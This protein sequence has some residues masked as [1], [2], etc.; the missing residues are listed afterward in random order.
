MIDAK[1][2]RRVMRRV[3]GRRIGGPEMEA[4]MRAHMEE[5]AAALIAEGVAPG[6]ARRRARLAFGAADRFQEEAWDARPTRWLEHLMRDVRFAVRMLLRS[7]GYTVV[8]V[9]TL[10]LGIG[11]TT[12]LFT[13]VNGVLLRPLPYDDPDGL[14]LI[15]ETAEEGGWKLPLSAGNYMDVKE[16]ASAFTGMAA[17]RARTFSLEE[18]DGAV[19]VEGARV[20]AGLFEVMG[21]RPLLGRTFDGDDDVGG[22]APVVMLS[23]A[24]WQQ[25]FGGSLDVIGRTITLSGDRYTIIGVMPEEFTFP[26]GAEL[27]APFGFPARTALWTPMAWTAAEAQ[28]RGTQNLVVVARLRPDV[29]LEAARADLGTVARSMGDVSSQF[30]RGASLTAGSLQADAVAPVRARLLL[31]LAMATFVMLI[32]CVNVANLVLTR[33]L[34][35]ERELSL[36][37]ALGAGTA[38]V[39]LQVVTETLILAAF[40]AAAAIVASIAGT[41]AML[42]LVP[43][44]LPRADDV[45]VDATVLV[46]TIGVATVIGVTFGLAS[47]VQVDRSRLAESLAASGGRSTGRRH[48][49]VRS[50]LIAVEVAFA[51]ILLVGA[52]LLVTSFMRLQRV[53]TGFDHEHV[54]AADLLVPSGPG[55]DPARDGPRWVSTFTEVIDRLEQEP[56]IEIA[57]GTSLL[58]LSGRVETRS[59]A[60]DGRPRAPDA[61]PL[62]AE[63]AATAPGYLEALRIPIVRGRTL[64]EQDREDAPLVVVVNEAFAARHFPGENPIGQRLSFTFTN[65]DSREIVGVAANVRSRG[66][67]AEVEP[68]IYLPLRQMPYPFLSITVRTRPGVIA[69]PV[70]FR[71]A[72]RTVDAGLAWGD[73]RPLGDVVAAS[74]AQRRFSA[75]LVGSFAAVALVLTVVGLYGMIAFAA[76]QRTRE[77]GVR[78]ALGATARDLLRLVVSDGVR[79]TFAGIAAGLIGAYSLQGMVRAQLYEVTPT[80]PRAYLGASLLLAVVAVAATLLPALRAAR[81][82]PVRALR[83]E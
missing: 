65:G 74:I 22:A 54:F 77:L 18:V 36:R 3:F 71:A 63:Y 13:V 28:N 57:A 72:L 27:P 30:A 50:V 35:R 29:T 68:V 24:L 56:G 42:S 70:M 39:G 43:G 41:R 1:V 75:L 49:V 15:W 25:R 80:D 82:D 53:E 69:S 6:E 2:L 66:L 83:E 10:A 32:A 40:A 9:G 62:V 7:P 14:A 33:A 58:P 67:D 60:I 46:L 64:R 79:P 48:G 78:M 73:I 47:L 55:F 12:S 81:I 45:A 20:G 34:S 26:R 17:F 52:T 5:E 37:S 44:Q 16:R 76:R 21:V 23:Y 38:R 31:L 4:E 61:P 11:A 8:A 59:F 19:R 51:M